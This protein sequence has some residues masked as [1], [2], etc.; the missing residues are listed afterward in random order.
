MEHLHP[1]YLQAQLISFAKTFSFE[2]IAIFV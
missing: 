1:Q 2:V